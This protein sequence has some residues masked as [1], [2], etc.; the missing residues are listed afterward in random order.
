MVLQSRDEDMKRLVMELEGE[1][2]SL[3]RMLA[4]CDQQVGGENENYFNQSSPARLNYAEATIEQSSSDSI[5]QHINKDM[6]NKNID[7]GDDSSREESDSLDLST[8]S[9]PVNAPNKHPHRRMFQWG[10]REQPSDRQRLSSSLGSTASE[11][12]STTHTTPVWHRR[13]N[14]RKQSADEESISSQALSV[15]SAP[16]FQWF[17]DSNRSR[18]HSETE[19]HDDNLFNRMFLRHSMISSHNGVPRT[20]SHEFMEE[21]PKRRETQQLQTLNLKLRGCDL[22]KSSLQE[23]HTLQSRNLLDL[24]RDHIHT[25]IDHEVQSNN[26]DTQLEEM[27]SK[28]IYCQRENKRRL[29]LLKEAMGKAKKANDREEL[30]LEEVECVRTELFA[31]NGKLEGD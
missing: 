26:I 28:F 30:L 1:L 19:R 15:S 31:L 12:N 7:F 18:R 14:S 17:S 29:R 6:T 8:I 27:R 10:K 9:T 22:A 16:I 23:L 3:E 2:Q 11:S 5:P 21:N 13:G 24:Q 25:Q 20:H 4:D